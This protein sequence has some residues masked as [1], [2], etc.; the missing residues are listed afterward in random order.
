MSNSKLPSERSSN[1]KAGYIASWSFSR[2]TEF[3]SC[4]YRTKLKVVDKIPEPERPLK[5]GQTEHANDRGTRIHESCELYVR[6][7]A[8]LPK[9]AEKFRDVFESLKN[10]YAK[11]KATLE[12]EWGFDRNWEPCEYKDAWLKVKCDAVVHRTS[13]SIAVIDYKTG[14]KKG[15]E[16]KH[17]EQVQLYALCAAIKYPKAENITVELWYLDQDDETVETKSADKWRYALKLFNNRGLKMT[18]ETEFKPSPSV[19]ACQYCP[20]NQGICEHAVDLKSEQMKKAKGAL[21]ARKN[22]KPRAT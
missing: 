1:S 15:N 16:I 9:E 18:N 13:K 11:G 21:Y 12:E 3:E 5:P 14:R 19:F 7:M 20:Y 6:D 2:L 4:K 17:A 10:W 22:A 8:P